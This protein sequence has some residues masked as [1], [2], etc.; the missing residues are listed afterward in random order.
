MELKAES[1]KAKEIFALAVECNENIKAEPNRARLIVAA[2]RPKLAAIRQQIETLTAGEEKKRHLAF[3]GRTEGF[4]GLCE[5]MQAETYE[6]I[7]DGAI[8]SLADSGRAI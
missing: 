8:Q 3:I 1:A 4:L 5:S 2:T 6:P 7:L